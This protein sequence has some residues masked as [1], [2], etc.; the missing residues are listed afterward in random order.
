MIII[1]SRVI[2]QFFHFFKITIFWSS[3]WGWGIKSDLRI[4]IMRNMSLYNRL[5]KEQ[6]QIS[7]IFFKLL[8]Y[9]ETI[10]LHPYVSVYPS[11]ELQ[12]KKLE[13]LKK[14]GMQ[15]YISVITQNQFFQFLEF[16]YDYNFSAIRY[17]INKTGMLGKIWGIL[18]PYWY[19]LF[20]SWLISAFF[21][22][23][24]KEQN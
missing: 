19:I 18:S 23:I 20:N 14:S 12:W 21:W 15:A 11:T 22:K 7:S 10:S 4:K 1:L 2:I 24:F 5:C 9:E 3:K 13:I 6:S 8:I 17:Q 16:L